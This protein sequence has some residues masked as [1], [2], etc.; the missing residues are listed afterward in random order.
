MGKALKTKKT[1]VHKDTLDPDFNRC[2]EFKVNPDDLEKTC[3]TIELMHSTSPVLKQDRLIG[4]VYIGGPLVSR[5]KELEH[6]T[7]AVS[8]S[9]SPVKEWH[10][11]KR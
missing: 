3:L 2:F 1:N 7:S 11:L 10:D 9:N 8:R 4:K 6:W 5:G